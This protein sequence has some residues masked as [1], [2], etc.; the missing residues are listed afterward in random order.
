MAAQ[1]NDAGDSTADIAA[2]TEDGEIGDRFQGREAA[3]EAAGLYNG[4]ASLRHGRAGFVQDVIVEAGAAGPAG[5]G[6]HVDA[7]V[8]A[9]A[10]H[11]DRA[12][13]G[14]TAEAAVADIAPAEMA[15]EGKRTGRKPGRSLG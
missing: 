13:A 6:R 15:I 8:V 9:L 1:K 7:V 10:I 11:P 12:V 5:A 14:R 2:L 3:A 4:A